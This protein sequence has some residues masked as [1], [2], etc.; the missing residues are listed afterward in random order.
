MCSLMAD[1][2]RRDFARPGRCERAAARRPGRA[3]HDGAADEAQED[4]DHREAQNGD[5]QGDYRALDD[6]QLVSPPTT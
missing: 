1:C 2:A 3:E 5:Q 6:L 4:G